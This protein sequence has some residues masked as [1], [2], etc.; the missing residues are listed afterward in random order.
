MVKSGM[1][2]QVIHPMFKL[3]R[4]VRSLVESNAMKPTDRI[5]KMAFMYGEE[6]SYWK[7][8]LQAYDFTMQDP[9]SELLAVEAWDDD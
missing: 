8:E 5:W 1:K 6:W 9:V 7:K 2:Q 4:K 3:Q